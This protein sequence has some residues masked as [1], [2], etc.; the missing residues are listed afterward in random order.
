MRYNVSYFMPTL[1]WLCLLARMPLAKS[2]PLGPSWYS[3]KRVCLP[4]G[5]VSKEASE[6]AITPEKT[7][8]V[9][10]NQTW[11]LK[12][13]VLMVDVSVAHI[14]RLRRQSFFPSFSFC[15]LAINNPDVLP[16]DE[17]F[18]KISPM[19]LFISMRI[20]QRDSAERHDSE[21]ARSV[22][23]SHSCSLRGVQYQ[24]YTYTE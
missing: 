10:S 18:L 19:L 22:K 20:I 9:L 3:K 12:I 4:S 21:V 16:Y 24:I 5:V 2:R 17:N 7:Q 8:V 23:G 15:K 6:R 1:C 14:S 11:R 13:N